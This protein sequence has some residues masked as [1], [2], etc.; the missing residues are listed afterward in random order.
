MSYKN[1]SL[2]RKNRKI[3]FEKSNRKC[4]WCGEE[5]KH[6][7][8]I[9]RSK[10]NH[11]LENLIPLCISCHLRKAHNTGEKWTEVR[12]E[13]SKK[14]ITLFHRNY[15]LSAEDLSSVLNIPKRKLYYLHIT[16]QL[17]NIVLLTAPYNV[18]RDKILVCKGMHSEN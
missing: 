12:K 5:A 6:L 18:L 14:T 15:G 13:S 9:D 8:H 3:V 17:K 7:H 4:D 10:D 16:R 2:L 11:S 1:T